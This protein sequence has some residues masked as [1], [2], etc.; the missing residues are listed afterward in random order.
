ME[1]MGGDRD[2]AEEGF[3]IFRTQVEKVKVESRSLSLSQ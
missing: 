2:F 1:K 3:S